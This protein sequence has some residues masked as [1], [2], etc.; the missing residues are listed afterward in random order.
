M[1][2]RELA[3]L[4]MITGIG[5]MMNTHEARAQSLSIDQATLAEQNAKTSQISTELLRR[6][7]TDKSAVVLDSRSRAEYDAGHIPGAINLDAPTKEQVGTVGG[8]VG[9]DKT[10]AL[11]LYCNGPYCQASRGLGER[12]VEAGF[13]NV[14]RYQLGIPIWRALGGPTVQ[15]PL[16]PFGVFLAPA[17]AIMLL[18]GD[19]IL[20]RVFPPF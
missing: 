19:Q 20:G 5:I 12:L 15:L 1:N 2:S 9:G 4:V 18:W 16:V 6:I 11:V 13:T 3:R 14:S 10:K 8:L 17:S 7:L